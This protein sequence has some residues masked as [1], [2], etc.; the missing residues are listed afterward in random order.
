MECFSYHADTWSIV[1]LARVSTNLALRTRY[2]RADVGHDGALASRDHDDD[3]GV[4]L[5]P[6]YTNSRFNTLLIVRKCKKSNSVN[7]DEFDYPGVEGVK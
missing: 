1:T 2:A 5:Q 6:S 7:T 3:H 4:C